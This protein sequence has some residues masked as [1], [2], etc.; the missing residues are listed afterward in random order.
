MQIGEWWPQASRSRLVA[1]D[2]DCLVE[3]LDAGAR[4]R[5][6][7]LPSSATT[8]QVHVGSFDARPSST[9]SANAAPISWA[10]SVDFCGTNQRLVQ[11]IIPMMP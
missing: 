10:L 5:T 8:K 1:L 6:W 3:S 2:P 4:W 9:I 11:P 7:R